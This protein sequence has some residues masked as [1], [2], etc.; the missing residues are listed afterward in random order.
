VPRAVGIDRDRGAVVA[1]AGRVIKGYSDTRR[2]AFVKM[3][4]LLDEVVAPALAGM[5]A[6]SDA[7]ARLRAANRA[8]LADEDGKALRELLA[9]MRSDE[10][11]LSAA[12]TSDPEVAAAE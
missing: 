6:P 12:S 3:I 7:A 11:S 8:A 9:V 2:R 5:V 4:T 10:P 1:E